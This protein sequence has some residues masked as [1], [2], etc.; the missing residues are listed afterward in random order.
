MTAVLENAEELLVN[1]WK[2]LNTAASPNKLPPGHSPNNQNVWVDEK[3]G[4]VLTANGYTFLGRLPS[5]LPVTGLINFF[6]SSDGTSQV[7]CTDGQNVYWTTDY[8]NYT[9]ITTGLSQYFQLRGKVI[10]NKLWLTNGSDSVMTWD[11]STLVELDGTGGTPN[12]PKGKFLEYH[13]ERV[14]MYGID[15]D[16]SAS[17]FS[18]LTNS[19]GT[20]IAPDNA[21]A[22]PTDNEIQI[23]EGDADIGT[24]IFLYRGYLYCS[25]QY[26]VWRIVGYDEYTYSR[27]KTRAST[28]TRFQESIQIKD[29]LVHFLGV[30]GLYVFDGEEAKRISDIID[31]ASSDEGVFAFRN[32]Q[33]PLLNNQFWNVSDTADFASGNEPTNLSD[34][35][36]E[37]RLVPVDDSQ[38]DFE[39][40]THSNTTATENPGRV[41]L[42]FDNTGVSTEN[43]ALAGTGALSISDNGS[44]V[45][46]ASYL[47]NGNL[48]DYA[49]FT[50][51]ATAL[52]IVT[53]WAV[54]FS[55]R[56][57]SRVTL[58][59]FYA[60]TKATDQSISVCRLEYYNGSTWNA[61]SG[62][63]VTFPSFVQND[64]GTMLFGH[65]QNAPKY[66]ITDQ[67]IT[68][69]FNLVR[70][71]GIRLNITAIPPSNVGP[72]IYS[73]G[74]A[75]REM[76]I[77]RSA[78]ES[79]GTFTSKT[80]DYG[81]IPATFGSLTADITAN[82]ETLQ[83]F[84]QSSADNSIW[85]AAVNVANGGS[86][87][88]T[89]RRYL[90][91]GVTLTSS[92]GLDSPVVAAV[93]VGSTY[94]SEVHD[95]G[96]NIYQWAPLQAV[97]DKAGQTVNFYYRA[98]ATS[99]LVASEAWTAI[100]PGAVPA[101]DPTDQFIQIKI[102]FST[103]SPLNRPSVQSFTVNWILDSGTG[104]NTL[105]N[106]ASIIILNRYWLSAATLGA[107]ANDVV[108]VL[109]KSTFGSPWMKKDFAF[110]SFCRFQDYYL[111][112]S[113]TDGAIYRLETG[114]SKNGAAMD[115]FY[116]TADLSKDDFQMKGYEIL[117]T[118]ERS[119]PYNLNVGWSTD[120]GLTWTEKQMDLTRATGDSLLYTKKF[121]IRFMSDAIR[122]RVRI[123]AADQPF[124]VDEI[125]VYYRPITQRG[126]LI[127]GS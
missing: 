27:V 19:S 120:G 127:S 7:V 68:V 12:V 87:G 26:S 116:E 65:N 66:F 46:L 38:A 1:E 57:V 117:V 8:V 9:T 125:K 24:G 39:A 25:K 23:S 44:F 100:V 3:P 94:L 63:S 58:K 112:G 40:G 21:S 118:A 101:A 113:S 64:S 122:F 78:Y 70:C 103:I 114:Y 95:T 126:T 89:A 13:D 104:I 92:T 90:R 108:I 53:T 97:I 82:G 109:G 84:T 50:V 91:W 56:P 15:G 123:N 18:A 75:M 2:T 61:V 20:Q 115:S 96:G 22:W 11:G 49:G 4:S 106:V 34:A 77:F 76:Q 16:L 55:E 110:L 31:P 86:I 80:L 47:N 52:Q 54:T 88:S 28:G 98:A 73:W 83:F 33:Q 62:G 45:G 42:D 30:D 17:R 74:I 67:D 48:S 32:L 14:W 79:T 41:Q 121:N 60:E 35:N 6:K 5:D 102:E 71:Q 93:F 36:D 119:G 111:A 107:E 81:S 85:D 69:S 99:L 72:N 29:N 43:V 59:S 105:Q 10:R 124:S 37:L 51:R